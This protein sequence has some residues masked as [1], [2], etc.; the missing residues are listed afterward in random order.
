MSRGS[1]AYRWF[2]PGDI[3]GF[4]G[5]IIDNL[6]VLSFLS[7]ILVFGFGF[8]A[9]IVYTRLF[10]GTAVGVLFGNLI[11]TW[12]AFNLSKKSGNPYV[13]AMPL[14]LDTPSTIGLALV[15][16]GPAYTALKAQGLSA[17]NAA[18]MTWYIGMALMMYMGLIK[19]FLSFFGNWVQKIIPKA[20]LLG[21]LAGIGLGLIGMLPLVDIFGMPLVGVISMGLIFYT[22]VA[23][24][25]L[26]WK[27]PGVFA[28]VL[29]GTTLYYLFA[30]FGLV[31]GAYSPPPPPNF[32]FALPIPTL[33]FIHGLKPALEFLPLAVPFA[34]LT[35]VGGINVTESARVAGDDYNTRNILLT[36]AL[37]TLIAGMCGGVAQ[38]TPYIGQPAYKKMGSRA[39]Y[40]LL[41]GIF[42]GIGGMTGQISYI[43][44]LIPRAVLAPILVFV[45][46]EIIIQA[47]LAVPRRHAPA[48]AFAFFPTIARMIGIE[49]SNPDFVPLKVFNSLLTA[50]GK[51]LPELQVI[52]ALGNGFI[53]S[54]M[55]WAAF[56]VKLIDG[57]LRSSSC[58]LLILAGLSFFGI[59][60]SVLPDGSMYLPWTL[61]AS[62]RQTPYQFALAYA[63]LAVLFLLLYLLP[64][65]S[66]A[67]PTAD[68][69]DSEVD[70]KTVGE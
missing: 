3:N 29:L 58:Y 41:T 14:G 44:E 32:N 27:I 42:I 46:L 67:V 48:V 22:L 54:A 66:Q 5:L 8:P 45:A 39:G 47:F 61:P 30:P 13:T 70:E 19:L 28:A 60:H 52:L 7:G 49:L 4:F 31:G 56:L 37:A 55:L 65:G 10:P 11:Y 40:T 64:Q 33:G 21:S 25:R 16:L 18:T 36:E 62:M 59:V 63:A 38:T 51:T 15:V 6:T 35:V 12:M 23:G 57:K 68:Q 53:I 26:P 34:L 2:V 50:P 24:N 9:D 69:S 17:A 20:G 43:V 1:H